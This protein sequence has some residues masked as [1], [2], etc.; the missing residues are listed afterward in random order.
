MLMSHMERSKAA[1]PRLARSF[2][3]A[4]TS[5]KKTHVASGWP[6]LKA[7]TSSLQRSHSAAACTCMASCGGSPGLTPRS[8]SLPCSTMFPMMGQRMLKMG[9]SRKAGTPE[10]RKCRAPPWYMAFRNCESTAASRAPGLARKISGVAPPTA[11]PPGIA[12]PPSMPPPSKPPRRPP[13]PRRPSAIFM[14]KSLP[15]VWITTRVC[16]R[17]RPPGPLGSCG[18]SRARCACMVSSAQSEPAAAKL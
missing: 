15:Q 6:R 7:S 17:S 4:L 14:M 8:S 12:P 1:S 18:L 2:S 13:P 5:S 3:S 9:I 16:G 10:T 11:G